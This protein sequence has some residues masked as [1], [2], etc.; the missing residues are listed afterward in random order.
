MD[1]TFDPIDG[2]ISC[3]V[4]TLNDI[5]YDSIITV[6]V[7]VITVS[8]N[9]AIRVSGVYVGAYAVTNTTYTTWEGLNRWRTDSTQLMVKYVENSLSCGCSPLSSKIGFV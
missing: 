1:A 3:L 8:S 7:D 9:G 2:T 4:P 6:D 5:S